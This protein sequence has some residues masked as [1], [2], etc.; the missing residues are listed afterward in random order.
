MYRILAALA[1][2]AFVVG[3]AAASEKTDVMAV[4]HQ[5]I[6]ATNKGG[7]KSFEA[8]CTEQTVIR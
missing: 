1:V 2:A 5:W 3:Q 6:D 8:L 7:M 4:V